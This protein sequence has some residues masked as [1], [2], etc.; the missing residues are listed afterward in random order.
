[1]FIARL[2]RTAIVAALVISGT[3]LYA[4]GSSDQ[5]TAARDQAAARANVDAM[6]REHAEDTAAPSPA[7]EIPPERAVISETLP[8]A[9]LGDQLVYGYFV[10]PSDMFEPLPAVIMIH[11]WW[12]LNDN[13]RAMAD[14]LAGE[15]YIVLAVDL[16]GGKVAGNSAEARELMLSVV[17]DPESANANIRSAYEFV[18]AT[19]GAPRVGSLGWCFGGGWSLNTAQLFPDDLDATVIYYGQV[20][21][22]ED[23]L[24]PIN[25]PILGLFAE[26]DTGIKVSSVKAFGEALRNLRKN[27]DIHVYPGVGHAFANPTGNNYNETAATDAW[28]RTLEF[29]DLHLSVDAS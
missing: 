1:M 26:E 27:H 15:G 9:E 11:E 14:R 4:C 28:R 21:S 18:S 17:E 25:S 5:D 20:T 23:K 16:Y 6:T 24:R 19:A 10:A 12:G 29:L 8:Y 13:I 3:L 22:D 7:A 2:R